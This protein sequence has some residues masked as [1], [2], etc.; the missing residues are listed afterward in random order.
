MKISNILVSICAAAALVPRGAHAGRDGIR[1]AG[2]YMQIAIPLSGLV[3]S[4]IIGDWDGSLQ[5]AESAGATM[6]ATYILKYT[7]RE[8]RPY[9]QEDTPGATFPSGHTSF[10]FAGAGYWQM[11]YGWWVGAPM[12][13]AAAFVGYS[14]VLAR[15]H[16]WLDVSVGA[17]IGIG[18]NMLFTTR[19]IPDGLSVA[20]TDGGAML[21]F[22][23]RF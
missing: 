19:Y 4:A 21:R 20:P 6:A 13:A 5:L 2:D 22:N 18:F 16:N 1:V 17:A 10:A 8:E 14:R 9:Q 7:I 12:Y 15:Q 3:Y 23:T 11:R